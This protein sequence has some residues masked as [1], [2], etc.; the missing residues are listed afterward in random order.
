LVAE[1]NPT[2][3]MV[4]M[5]LLE[6]AGVAT[7]IVN[8]GEEALAALNSQPFDLVLMDI[9]MPVMS[10][11]DA[12]RAIRD[13]KAGRADIPIIALTADAMKEDRIRLIASGFD[14]HLS[15]P[16]TPSALFESISGLME[17]H[18]SV[19]ATALA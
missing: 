11:P 6:A 2:N 17:R 4:V 12:M 18:D 19:K 13:G 16:F 10:G 8:N 3:Q 15:K 5:A 9:H 1:D 7:V 14:D